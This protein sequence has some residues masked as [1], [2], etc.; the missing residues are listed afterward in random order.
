MN[1]ALPVGPT[2]LGWLLSLFHVLTTSRTLNFTTYFV[3]CS[4]SLFYSNGSRGD[5]HSLLSL[6]PASE[7]HSFAQIILHLHYQATLWKVALT[8]LAGHTGVDLSQTQWTR[9]ACCPSS[10][11]SQ[12]NLGS[13][14][15]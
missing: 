13:T 3:L 12:V 7:A 5:F 6:A 2:V 14:Q 8:E 4:T 15:S 11:L 9:S 10:S 1:A